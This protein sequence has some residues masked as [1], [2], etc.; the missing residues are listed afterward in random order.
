MACATRIQMIGILQETFSEVVTLITQVFM[1][2]YTLNIADR[3]AAKYDIMFK[4]V[5]YFVEISLSGND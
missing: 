3:T 5:P 2:D 4:P 1:L